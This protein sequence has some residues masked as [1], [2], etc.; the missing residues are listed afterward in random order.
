MKKTKGTNASI[1]ELIIGNENGD[2]PPVHG[3]DS[4]NALE[5]HARFFL[6]DLRT[7]EIGFLWLNNMSPSAG[8]GTAK[9]VNVFQ[10]RTLCRVLSKRISEESFKKSRWIF[11]KVH[12][13]LAR[14]TAKQSCR[15]KSKRLFRS[16]FRTRNIRPGRNSTFHIQ[17]N[18]TIFAIR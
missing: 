6:C 13:K 14:H 12:H 9:L 17:R 8:D 11:R 15:L 16:I 2:F 4:A 7:L 10:I 5:L 18:I 1:F 3:V